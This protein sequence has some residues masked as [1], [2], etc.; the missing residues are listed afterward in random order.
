MHCLVLRM[1]LCRHLINQVN[2]R[3]DVTDCRV[4][5]TNLWVQ[6]EVIDHSAYSSAGLITVGECSHVALETQ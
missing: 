5:V 1:T 3:V 2:L 6:I 4:F